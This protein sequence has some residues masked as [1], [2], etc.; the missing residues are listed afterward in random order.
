M[1][2]STSSP[3]R[4][5]CLQTSDARICTSRGGR[6]GWKAIV[7]EGRKAALVVLQDGVKD[8]VHVKFNPTTASL[9]FSDF[10]DAAWK[11]TFTLVRSLPDTILLKGTVNGNAVAI[12][13]HRELESKLTKENGKFQW[14]N[15]DE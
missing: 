8:W 7:F 4:A 9:E 15:P 12:A 10:D 3:R 1:T 2:A 5:S 13:L 6:D 14:V 11:C